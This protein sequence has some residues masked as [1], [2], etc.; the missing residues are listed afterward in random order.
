MMVSKCVAELAEQELGVRFEPKLVE[1]PCES[2]EM[3]VEDF[4][5]DISKTKADLGWEPW[6]IVHISIR[7]ILQ[8]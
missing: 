4:T 1:N 3:L 6:Y 2:S 7:N 5:V 8:Y